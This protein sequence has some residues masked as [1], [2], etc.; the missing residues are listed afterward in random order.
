MDTILLL[1]II[2][3]VCF[4]LLGGNIATAF[5]TKKLFSIKGYNGGFFLGLFLGIIGLIYAV[6]LPMQTN[7]YLTNNKKENIEVVTELNNDIQ[8]EVIEIDT[9][10]PVENYTTCSNCGFPIYED[11]TECSNCGTKR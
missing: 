10:A 2:I 5:L 7:E 8:E 3:V 11:E 4:L 6:G 1:F 9:D